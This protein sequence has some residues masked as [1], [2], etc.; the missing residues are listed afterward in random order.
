[1]SLSHD[2]VVQVALKFRHKNWPL[3]HMD[4]LLLLYVLWYRGVLREEFPQ[5]TCWWANKLKHAETLSTEIAITI[6]LIPFFLE[7]WNDDELF[8]TSSY[9]SYCK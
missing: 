3:A 4:L 7:K 1:M 5:K 9:V 8:K 6:S 2:G